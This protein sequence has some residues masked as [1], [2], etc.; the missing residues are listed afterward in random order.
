[1]ALLL[2][3][4]SLSPAAAQV[5]S[6]VTGT[7][8]GAVIPS[9]S[10]LMTSDTSPRL[11][12][13]AHADSRGSFRFSN[14]TP[15]T[16]RLEFQAAGFMTVRIGP[17]PVSAGDEP[18]IPTLRLEPAITPECAND[19]YRPAEIHLLPRKGVGALRLHFRLWLGQLFDGDVL[20]T[21]IQIALVNGDSELFARATVPF[22][23]TFQLAD[24]PPG[25]YTVQLKAEGFYAESWKIIVRE[26]FDTEY[27]MPFERC[28]DNHCDPRLRFK[29]QPIEICY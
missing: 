29:D 25:K 17:F 10:V 7:I 24:L 2:A 14:V 13:I 23:G 3:L 12:T 16:Y 9:A 27:S 15:G 8:S 18:L 20:T 4:A 11:Q 28:R 6:S 1:M 22:I 5:S 26:G 21:K 19:I